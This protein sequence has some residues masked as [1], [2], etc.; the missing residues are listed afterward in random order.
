MI[1][2]KLKIRNFRNLESFDIN[3]DDK[4]TVLVANNSSGKT[5]ILDAISIILGSY[6]GAFPTEKNNG[7][8]FTDAT[9]R[10]EEM[11]LNIL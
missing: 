8:R 3:F 2:K 9:I 6:I 7:F 5:S 11:N 10:K 4:L 1:I